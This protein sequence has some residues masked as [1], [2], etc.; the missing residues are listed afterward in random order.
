MKRLIF[1]LFALAIVYS[2]AA[3]GC[4]ENDKPGPEVPPEPGGQDTTVTPPLPQLWLDTVVMHNGI[5]LSEFMFPPKL[6]YQFISFV[7]NEEGRLIKFDSYYGKGNKWDI[8][9][10]AVEWADKKVTM[11]Y[12]ENNVPGAA[13]VA[14]YT[15]NDKWKMEKVVLEA[16]DG[17][18]SEYKAEYAANEFKMRDL[19][20]SKELWSAKAENGNAYGDW[21]TIRVTQRENDK[22]DITIH[23]EYADDAK[24]NYSGLDLFLLPNFTSL[25][26]P[27]C[28]LWAYVAG[29]LPG[30]TKLYYNATADYGSKK[31]MWLYKLKT[32]ISEEKLTLLQPDTKD[33]GKEAIST[34]KVWGVMNIRESADTT[35]VFE[36]QPK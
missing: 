31:S 19:T 10:V 32:E 27:K 30:N 20:R 5:I 13:C 3:Q 17:S 9:S 1:Y 12:N 2:M 34:D 6:G 16:H 7:Y 33:Y 21:T 24:R 35:K 25:G 36:R 8:D 26:T 22:P 11:R 14:T 18:K 15:L 4:S 23:L 29:L 28:I